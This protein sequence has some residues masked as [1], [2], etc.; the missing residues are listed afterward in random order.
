MSAPHPHTHT[1][2]PPTHPTQRMENAYKS[3][4]HALLTGG[5]GLLGGGGSSG[6][7]GEG[8]LAPSAGGDARDGNAEISS[9]DPVKYEARFNDFVR[10]VFLPI[11]PIGGP[12]L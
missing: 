3:A 9:V 1:P 11:S 10:R 6:T 12:A 4:R 8:L 5:R 2:T 7:S